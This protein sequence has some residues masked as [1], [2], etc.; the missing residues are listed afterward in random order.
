MYILR[1]NGSIRFV[2]YSVGMLMTASLLTF[3]RRTS[4]LSKVSQSLQS[5]IEPLS[6]LVKGMV[7]KYGNASLFSYPS[8]S[9]PPCSGSLN[10]KR[11]TKHR[12]YR[13]V[14][15]ES[16]KP[17]SHQ[18]MDVKRSVSSLMHDTFTGLPHQRWTSG[19]RWNK[20]DRVR[21]R[22]ELHDKGTP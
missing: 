18:G 9:P 8:L 13:T 12:V 7:T 4:R 5:C 10:Y 21:S 20:V 11:R 1:T 14:C 6:R 15:S 2:T 19:L 3:D 22:Q 17:L 16:I